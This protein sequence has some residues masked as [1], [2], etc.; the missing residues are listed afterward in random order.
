M[1]TL[2]SW[3]L[4]SC[5]VGAILLGALATLPARAQ[6]FTNLIQ[7]QSP[8]DYW[9]FNEAV[10]AP[11]VNTIANLGSLGAIGTG[12]VVD[13]ALTG[14]P[15][16]VGNSV[17]LINTGDGT[18]ICDTRV[19]IP[20][21]AALNPE[22]PFTIEFWASP[23]S[24]STD[25]T[26]LAVLSSLSPYP[27][28]DSRSG[29]LFYLRSGATAG[30]AIYT[31]RTGGEASYNA[32]AASASVPAG[33]GT[34]THVVGTFDGTTANIYINGV[35]SGSGT[36][37]VSQPFHVNQW[38]PTRL[39]GTSLNGTEYNQYGAGNRGYDGYIDE[40][41]IYNTLLSSD[42]IMSHYMA[43]TNSPTPATYDALILASSPAGYWNMDEPAYTA[44]TPSFTT[45]ADLG[46]LDDLATNT[47][48]AQAG[49]PG[50]PGLSADDHSV[51]YNGAGGSLVLNTGVPPY[52]PG[53]NTGQ[54]LTLAAWIMPFTFGGGMAQDIIAQGYDE[55]T[56][57]ENY[58]RVAD[59]YDW[60]DGNGSPD[61][62]YY[63]VGTYN[64]NSS[65][66]YVSAIAP[67]PAGDIGHWVFLVGTYDGA[68]WN[69]YRNGALVATMPDEGVGPSD[70]SIP[71]SVGS[72]SSPSQYMGFFFDGNIEEASIFTNTL[73]AGAI[74]NLYNSVALPPVIT[75]A[76][77]APSPAYLGSSASFSV[78]A[79]GPGTLAYQWYSNNVAIAGQTTT[80]FSL[81][82][83]TA[84]DD[85]TYSV[86]VSTAYGA[87]TSSV[88]LAVTPT[89]PPAILVPATETRWIGSP[90]SFAPA[91]LPNQT[92]SFQWD[93]NG[94][95]ISG[96]N[97]SFYTA[98]TVSGSVGSYTL[99]ISN[100]FGAATSSV[101]VLEAALTPPNNYV[102]TILADQPLSYFR[103][104]ET[105][106]TVG[107]DFAGGNNGN[108][109]GGYE[110]GQPGYSVIDPDPAVTFS[111]AVGSYLGDIGATAINF[112]GTASEFTIEA[113]ANGAAG[114]AG[115]A[116]VI[117]KGTGNNGG[118]YSSQFAIAVNTGGG[119]Y[120]FYVCD[121][122]GN[123]AEADAPT[124]PDG[125]WHHL[126]GV[127]DEIGGTL[128]FYIDGQV[129]ASTDF[130]ALDTAKILNSENPVSIGAQRSGVLPPYDYDYNG[131]ID[132][133]AIYPTAL[134][135]GQVLSHYVA[136]YGSNLA[137]V[138]T[139][140]PVSVTNYVNF[141]ATLSLGAYGSFPLNYTW[142]KAG[143]GAVSNGPVN[144]FTIPSLALSDAGTYTV[145]VANAVGATNSVPVTITVLPAPTS[146]P[147][148]AG[149]VMHLT[150]DNTL[151][152]A[153]GRGND[154]TNEASGGA[155]LITN[156]YVQGFVHQFAFTYQT[157]V[158][159]N[160]TNAGG[161]TNANYASVGVRPDLQFGAD[162]SFTVSMW[163]QLP[164]NYGLPSSPIA[165]NDLPFFTDTVGSTFGT[166]FVFAPS[167][168]GPTADWPGGWAFSIFGTGGGQGVYGTKNLINDGNWHSLIYVFNRTAATTAVYLDGFPASGT[169]QGAQ[170]ASPTVGNIDVSTGATIGQDPT[171]LYPQGGSASID[172]LGVWARALTQLEVE[173]IYLAGSLNQVSFTGAPTTFT[174]K[175][176]PGPQLQLTW[177]AGIIQSAT[178]LLGPWTDVAG[179]TSPYVV[180]PTE[181]QQYF[182]GKL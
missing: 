52:D 119:N 109:Y 105:N 146:A 92:L 93:F 20:N 73:D 71:W 58:L 65:G 32:T 74:S 178:N 2:K 41:A 22:P 163:V 116:A 84:A 174:L 81:N 141:P 112:P 100:S 38:V 117:A 83:L 130:S 167:Y 129:A 138:I 18:G 11:E 158:N 101:A 127:C 151:V 96:A 102:A 68:Q 113:W 63:D 150:F 169:A 85:A 106:G 172:D 94:N 97:Q 171:G 111:G 66:Y 88:V 17:Q 49:Q 59:T 77:V 180:S 136:A 125:T 122:K 12:Y 9:R 159:T 118:N 28:F 140:Q 166:G 139:I 57:I 26:G 121:D 124:G 19:D 110:L 126:V 56:G 8:I 86:I 14:A 72:R 55:S 53:A 103:L 47:L 115:G 54:P 36:A 78:W 44:P 51:H 173:S 99:V 161:T 29:Y 123:V 182:R 79:D 160:A 64:G 164:P 95:P 13:G 142:S 114:Q 90:L 61:V 70:L 33:I 67:A 170:V 21:N 162:I 42:V 98:P 144:S 107:Y 177:N 7:A 131:T 89:L 147:A 134:S 155:P 37:S 181:A 104:D 1:K 148:L 48:G 45:A 132:E 91:S 10:T 6:S 156:D 75:Q 3:K 25:T 80:N 23:T 128:T 135:P 133:V 35:L 152:D 157:T 4:G 153:T 76:P 16:V 165:G 50:V 120:R 149:L 87:V 179:A 15:G 176:L 40:F 30:T 46:S 137:P 143:T 34:W 154:A 69:L 175:V 5:L 39:G 82:G 24:I 108:Y 43:G 62:V 145:N 27:N 168:G 31:L 60:E